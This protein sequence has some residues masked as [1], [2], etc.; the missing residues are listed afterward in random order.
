MVQRSRGVR[1]KRT[2]I[3]KGDRFKVQAYV[4]ADEKAVIEEA[5]KLS[6]MGVS[7]FASRVVL[8]EAKRVLAEANRNPAP[9]APRSSRRRN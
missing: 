7:Y 6:D 5:A 3:G 9:P 1:H 8:A 2:N 4:S